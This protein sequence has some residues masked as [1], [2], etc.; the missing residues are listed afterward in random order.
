M[1]F[2]PRHTPDHTG[3]VLIPLESIDLEMQQT[4]NIPKICC[5]VVV[6]SRCSL[7]ELG[8]ISTF[9]AS[10]QDQPTYPLRTRPCCRIEWLQLSL[11]MS[12]SNDLGNLW[13]HFF[14]RIV[15]LLKDFK[16]KIQEYIIYLQLRII[17]LRVF[18]NRIFHLFQQHH[19]LLCKQVKQMRYNSRFYFFLLL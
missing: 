3:F 19:E 12:N 14:H 4:P 5:F 8:L 2:W 9:D 17:H 7:K 1:S 15:H 16:L 11:L 18:E 10:I 6:A 13:S